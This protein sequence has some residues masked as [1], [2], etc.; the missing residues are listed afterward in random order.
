D[1]AD[2]LA[3]IR[4]VQKRLSATVEKDG[5]VRVRMTGPPDVVRA[6]LDAAEVQLASPP[7]TGLRLEQ[8]MKRKQQAVRRL[9][10]MSWLVGSA[11]PGAVTEEER[12]AVYADVSRSEI[13]LA[14]LRLRQRVMVSR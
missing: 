4:W 14:P 8:A 3:R 5:V 13:E 2:D 9:Q 7:P 11:P 1:F 10:K 6:I 12:A